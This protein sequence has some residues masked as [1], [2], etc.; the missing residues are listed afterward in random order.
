LKR[1]GRGL[2]EVSV[3]GFKNKTPQSGQPVDPGWDSNRVSTEY[4][5]RV[6]SHYQRL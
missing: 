5:S 2:L 1:V 3:P 6:L 4:K